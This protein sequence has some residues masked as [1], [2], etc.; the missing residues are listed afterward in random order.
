MQI[1]DASRNEFAD[2]EEGSATGPVVGLD[3]RLNHRVI[4][5]RAPANQAIFRIKSA[6]TLIYTKCVIRS[7]GAAFS[8]ECAR[9]GVL[10]QWQRAFTPLGR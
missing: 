6:I 4:D 5:L 2:E 10:G 3:T 1:A 7:R 9:A 8:A